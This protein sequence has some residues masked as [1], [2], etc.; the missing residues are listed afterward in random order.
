MKD[1]N[2]TTVQILAKAGSI[3]ETRETN[4]ISHFL[5]HLFFK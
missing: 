4:G 5:E 1:S 3:Y 2:S